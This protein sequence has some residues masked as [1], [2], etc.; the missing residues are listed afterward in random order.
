MAAADASAATSAHPPP[1]ITVTFGDVAENHARMQKIGE[2]ANSGFSRADL[3]TAKERF[4]AAG[5][6][7][8]MHDLAPALPGDLR[9]TL[10]PDAVADAVVLVVRE[11]LVRSSGGGT[12]EAS[13][14]DKLTSE[15]LH[16]EWDTKAFMYGRV[17]N[18]RAR[19]NLCFSDISQDPDY[20]EGK[21]RVVA[22]AALTTLNRV[23][24]ELPD[25]LGPKAEKL[26]A[27]GNLYYDPARC[28]IGFHGD[29]ERRRVVALRL[30]TPIPF[31]YQWHHRCKK[32]GSP[33]DI[34]LQAGDLYVMGDK[35]VGSDWMK[36]AEPTLRHAAGCAKYTGV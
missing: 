25:Y 12:K 4:V 35:A 20:T 13:L 19:H 2:L 9:E 33:I 16:L 23:R 7:T 10:P 1:A 22:F 8:E 26:E 5:F 6:A 31:R 18:K 21:G 29:A 34:T 32:V 17:V 24:E 15:L 30:G 28:G 3:E 36:S 27:E 11:F 14:A